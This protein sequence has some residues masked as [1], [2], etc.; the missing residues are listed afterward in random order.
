[1]GTIA[2][3]GVGSVG[4]VYAAYLAKIGHQP[5]LC[6]REP[7][8]ELVVQTKGGEL[9]SAAA[10][11]LSPDAAAAQPVDWLFLA[12][13]AHQTE[14]AGDWLKALTGPQTRLVVLHNGVEHRER[15]TPYADQRNVVPTV[16]YCASERTAPGAVTLSGRASL[17]VENDANGQALKDLFGES[18]CEIQLKDDWATSA[19]EKLCANVAIGPLCALTVS[20][21]Q[22]LKRPDMYELAVDVMAECIAVATAEGAK[23]EENLADRLLGYMTRGT[24]NRPSST[25]QDRLAGRPMEQDAL[26]GAVVRAGVKHGIPT[27]LN[28]AVLAM[29]SAV[30][31]KLAEDATKR[32]AVTA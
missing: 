12:T 32:V 31:D 21:P 28:K 4:A 5:L 15:M 18:G 14:S 20:G 7:F 1:V 17:A 23:L 27:P 13:K 22:V 19:W 6:V 3:V 25:L 24:N 29:L 16:V 2:F 30:S 11:V 10:C 9:R 8:D 26:V